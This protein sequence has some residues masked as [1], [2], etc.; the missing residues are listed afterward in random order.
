MHIWSYTGFVLHLFYIPQYSFDICLNVIRSS[1][2]SDLL[3]HSFKLEI[4]RFGEINR[5][6][7][8]LK[9]KTRRNQHS[10]LQFPA[11]R[12]SSNC[13]GDD[14]YALF[15]HCVCSLARVY[16]IVLVAFVF[17]ARVYLATTYSNI[18]LCPPWAVK[19]LRAVDTFQPNFYFLS[20]H[21]TVPAGWMHSRIYVTS[22][23]DALPD[24]DNPFALPKC[25]SVFRK[26]RLQCNNDKEIK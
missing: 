20:F 10:L 3:S 16:N 2:V 1:I 12:F 13:T 4:A 8:R 11:P 26:T 23:D 24:T 6:I 18:R 5:S 22:G 14:R 7:A 25:K 21:D 15:N 9:R 17:C 19:P